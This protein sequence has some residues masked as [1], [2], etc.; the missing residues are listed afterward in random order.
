MS[1]ADRERW[2]QK[3]RAGHGAGEPAAALIELARYLPE[4]GRVLDVAGGA[5]RNAVWL[6][7]RSLEV[8]LVD[9]SAVAVEQALRRAAT[10]GVKLSALVVDLDEGPLPIGP[11]DAIV[12]T[13]FLHRPLFARY[14]ALLA[15]SGRLIV[16]HPTRSNLLKHSRP[17]AEFLLEDGELPQL[18][19]E[20]GLEIIHY[21]EGWTA[22]DRHEARLVAQP[23][24]TTGYRQQTSDG[25]RRR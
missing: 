12:C 7:A 11:W 22:A 13:Y 20:A 17:P 8:T 24:Q 10:A 15:P 1:T 16:V 21:E 18:V 23:L 6:A 5:G 14:P 3:Y 19:R 2:N 25:T 4:T 9:V